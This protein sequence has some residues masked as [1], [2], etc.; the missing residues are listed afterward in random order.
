MANRKLTPRQRAFVNEYRIDYNAT[1]AALAVGYAKKSAHVS[2][3]DLL[4]RPEIQEEIGRTGEIIQNRTNIAVEKI[5]S[6]LAKIAFFDMRSVMS[7]T[8]TGVAFIDSSK[9]D[10][11]S[12]AAIAQI[13]ETITQAGGTRSLKVHDKI[14]ALELLGKYLGMF[15]EQVEVTT[16]PF[17]EQV[18]DEIERQKK[19]NG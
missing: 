3:S 8:D 19:L 17:H 14:K 6:E 15:K 13:N 18:V 7:W 10:D 4:K 9:I 12:A 2:G 16:K 11:N 5:V 1:R